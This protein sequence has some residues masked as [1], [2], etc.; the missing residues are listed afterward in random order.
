LAMSRLVTIADLAV[1]WVSECMC[2]IHFS[3]SRHWQQL[4][5]SIITWPIVYYCLAKWRI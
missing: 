4:K 1:M 2:G 5:T 3:I